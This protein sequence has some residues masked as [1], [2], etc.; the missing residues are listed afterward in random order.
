MFDG[1]YAGAQGCGDAVGADGVRG[2]VVAEAVSFI[3]DG[4]G[5]VV[6]EIYLAV[7]DAVGFVV[8]AVIGIIFDPVGAM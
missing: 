4:A 2:Y 6:G 8:V 7:Q 5:F 3:D 1:V